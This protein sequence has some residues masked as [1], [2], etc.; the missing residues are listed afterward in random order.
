METL[1]QL[2]KQ[3]DISKVDEAGSITEYRLNSNGLRVLLSRN[4]S[5]PVV[6]FMVLFRIGSRNEAVGYTGA[7]HFLEHMKFKGTSERNP[8][9]NNGIDDLL[10]PI[11]ALYNATTWFDRTN[12]FE[13]VSSKHLDLC[14]EIEA[15][16]MRGLVLRQ[17]DR[18]SEMT[19]VRNELERGENEPDD[20]LMDNLY[21]FAFREHPYHHPTIG[22]RSDVEGVPMDR[23]REFYNTFYWPNNACAIVVGDFDHGEALKTIHKN[24][25]KIPQSPSPIPEVYT[26][27]P[28]QQGERRFE[29]RR[30]GDLPRVMI[31]YHVPEA[32]HADTYALSAME[33]VLGGSGRRSS[34]LYK[35][36]IDSGLASDCSA[37]HNQQHDPG[38]FVFS[39]T[40][41]PDIDPKSVEEAMLDEISKLAAAPP[42][43][44]ELQ[45][46]KSANRKST[47]LAAADPMMLA[48]QIGESEAVV[49]WKWYVTYDDNFDAVTVED[50]QKVAG[51][52]FS[53]DNRTVGYFI[54]KT[55]EELAAEAESA[56]VG[57]SHGSP[58][59][60][61]A[62]GAKKVGGP[63]QVKPDT[64]GGEGHKV[65]SASGSSRN[66]GEAHLAPTNVGS[67][68]GLLQESGKR[69]PFAEQVVIKKLKNGMTVVYMPNRNTGSVSIVGKL[70]AGYYFADQ[71]KSLIPSVISDMVTRGS[72]KYS[73]TVIA[74]ILEN[75][76]ASL[77]LRADNFAINF[78]SQVVT[79]DLPELFDVLSD[80]LINPIF[81]KDELEKC[82]TEFVSYITEKMTNTGSRARNQILQTLYPSES[83]YYARPFEMQI[84][85][86]KGM[87]DADLR[88][89]HKKQFSPQGMIL[90]IVGDIDEAQAFELVEKS[91]GNWTGPTPQE[92]S[93]PAVARPQTSVRVDVPIA[94]KA[95]V[96]IVIG[97]P[98]ELRRTDPDFF[99]AL[100]ANA[101]LGKDTLSSRLGVAVREKAGLTYGIYSGFDDVGFGSAPWMI[102]LSVNPDNIDRALGLISNV[103]DDY[104]SGGI[105]DKE[106]EDEKGRTEGQ[107]LVG[108]RT[109]YAIASTLAQYQFLG[110]DTAMLDG[111]PE[112][113]RAVTKDQVNEA[114]KKFLQ[115]NKSTTVIAGTFPKK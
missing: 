66:A 98:A 26:I 83:V 89:Y 63:S 94:D 84:E 18:D 38:L 96:D 3:L 13:C 47:I 8:D 74:E 7:T 101:A 28:P 25:G 35:R 10:K 37:W 111:F 46:A 23:L 91:F 112:K 2:L 103:V 11:G 51:T 82:Q 12:Y 6:T 65:S 97:H 95:N 61:I 40:V 81:A 102:T 93:V 70:R 30:A 107:F 85:E 52:Y 58:A 71:I 88:D 113:I 75:M 56:S 109:S 34:R 57:V 17:E 53:R 110:L 68:Q 20:V 79:S 44:D 49:D 16:R 42:N 48:R 1:E 105:S 72:A 22:W 31:G 41:N 27:E 104:V 55:E 19:V 73:K 90:S 33:S 78:G 62:G 24:F 100:L 77:S 106:L 115:I 36:L 5:A 50:V 92:I 86:I 108:L 60:G 39:A 32:S 15:D 29:I 114:I 45:R 64:N 76:G 87:T 9:K 59:A 80:I 21:A 99:A 67:G 4:A 69:K 14:V 54:P 43:A